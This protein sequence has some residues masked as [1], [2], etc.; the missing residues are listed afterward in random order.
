MLLFD[1]APCGNA[2]SRW[3]WGGVTAGAQTTLLA[4]F[5]PL[6]LEKKDI[7]NSQTHF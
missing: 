2:V 5:V 1:S 6:T 4:I 7:L 3:G